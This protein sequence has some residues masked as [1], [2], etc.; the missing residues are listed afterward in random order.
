[1]GEWVIGTSIGDLKGHII[2]IHSPIPSTTVDDINPALPITKK[3]T[4]IPKV[5]GPEGKAGFLSSTPKPQTLNPKTPNP[6]P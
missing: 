2:G 3:Y 6:K 1:M 5:Q 4:L